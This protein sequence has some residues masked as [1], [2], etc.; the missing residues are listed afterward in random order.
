MARGRPSDGIVRRLRQLE[1]GHLSRGTA[2]AQLRSAALPGCVR[3]LAQQEY[4]VEGCDKIF[5]CTWLDS[6]RFVVGTK[7]Y[8]LLVVNARTGGQHHVPLVAFQQQPSSPVPDARSAPGSPTSSSGSDSSSSPRQSPGAQAAWQA[9][10]VRAL[11]ANS[12]AT[13]LAVGSSEPQQCVVYRL[14]AF[15][16]VHVLAGHEH[17]IFSASF[18]TEDRLVTGS[19]DGT[20]KVWDCSKARWP[21]AATKPL[22]SGHLVEVR[23]CVGLHV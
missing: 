6:D 7:C 22:A 3:Q 18:L 11:A 4:D 15:Q 8:K 19:R 2:Q 1:A 23:A 16:P 20:V 21:E 14:P 9:A 12:T 13:L 5:A 10:G 17:W